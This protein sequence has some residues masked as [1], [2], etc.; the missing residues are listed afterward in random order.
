PAMYDCLIRVPLIFS[1]PGH[2]DVAAPDEALVSQVDVMP[3]VLSFI[4]MDI[5]QQ[6]QGFDLSKKLS[7]SNWTEKV[8]DVV[9]AEYGIP[10][11]SFDRQKLEEVFPDYK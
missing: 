10:G 5:P 11:A 9:F 6:A 1:W 4:G 2:I 8:R 3:T 7:S